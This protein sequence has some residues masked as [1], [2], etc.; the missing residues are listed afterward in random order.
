MRGEE[1][2]Q[3]NAILSKTVGSPVE[4]HTAEFLYV[5]E[6]RFGPAYYMVK[7]DGR[8]LRKHLFGKRY[9][10]E[11]S[12]WSADSRYLALSEWRSFSEARGPDTQ[13]VVIDILAKRECTVARARGGFEEPVRFEGNTLSTQGLRTTRSGEPSWRAAWSI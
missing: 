5:S 9:F 11:A 1:T 6:I 3:A 8:L 2:T 10:G 7:V 4:G 12:L 13:L